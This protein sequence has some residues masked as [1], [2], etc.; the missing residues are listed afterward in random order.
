MSDSISTSRIELNNNST[1]IVYTDIQ[2]LYRELRDMSLF[3]R[4]G[5]RMNNISN[6]ERNIL[7]SLYTTI[8]YG[9]GKTTVKISTAQK[10]SEKEIDILP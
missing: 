1:K 8:N 7:T 9:N 10:F 2:S 6:E 3:E 4:I 5:E